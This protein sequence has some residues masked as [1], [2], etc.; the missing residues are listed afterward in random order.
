MYIT[1]G[2]NMKKEDLE[3]FIDK[4][5]LSDL[6][7]PGS[8]P[9]TPRP[10]EENGLADRHGQPSPDHHQQTDA[11]LGHWRIPRKELNSPK[12]STQQL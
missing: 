3:K 6:N 4:Y 12:K 1:I 5:D 2:K 7:L 8:C 9:P 11:G 10:A